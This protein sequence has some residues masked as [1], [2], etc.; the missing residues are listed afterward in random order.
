MR[1]LA[2][3]GHDVTVISPF[4]ET[5]PCKNGSY[6]DIILTDFIKVNDKKHFDLFEIDK[7][8]FVTYGLMMNYLGNDNVEKTLSHP[9][10]QKLLKSNEKFDIVIVEQFV[11]DAL[12]AFSYYYKA[13]LVLF[14]TF[15]SNAWINPLVANPAPPSYIPEQKIDFDHKNF[16]HRLKN[17]IIYVFGELNRNLLFFPA[18][19]K[20]M[21]KYFPDAPDLD[22]ILYN[23]SL[24]LLNSHISTNKAVPRVPSMIDI[25][26]FHLKPPKKLPQGLQEF[27]DNAK[28]G[29]VYFSMGSALQ[30]V[31][32]PIEKREALLKVFS[33]LKEKVLWKWED[34]VLPG[35]P[36]NVKLEKWLPQQDI[37]A[38]PNIKAFITHGGLLSLIESVYHG[39]PILAIP[40][41]GDQVTN[42]M[43]A[44]WNGC[45]RYIL[46]SELNEKKLEESLKDILGNS[47]YRENMQ[48]RSKIMHDRQ[49]KPIDDAD[50]WIQYVIRHRGATHLRVAGLDLP[51]YQY[52]SL[53]VYLFICSVTFLVFYVIYN[54]IKFL[55]SFFRKNESK[56]KV[57]KH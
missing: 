23:A 10:V 11:N 24:V 17:N 57:K 55:I 9:N 52:L 45:G 1:G 13:P 38:H 54:S 48:R 20:I 35:Q 29:V 33:R 32:L 40:V 51:W 15:S 12:K 3:K 49:N 2:E 14:V 42:A 37:L 4:G 26:G 50:Y 7:M 6:K 21:K 39:V 43:E 19:N 53:D 44:T 8:D 34:D 5:T 27:L 47:K 16:F 25:G 18:Q 31:N 46:Y 36:S 56:E 28:E 22:N 30:S 41:F